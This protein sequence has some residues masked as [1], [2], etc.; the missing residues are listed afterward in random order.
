MVGVRQFN[1]EK[2]LD[3][4]MAVFWELGYEATSVDDLAKSTGLSRSSLYSAFG[5]KEE[6]FLKVIDRYLDGSRARFFDALEQDDLR[7]ALTD[8]LTILKDRLTDRKSKAGC[9]LVLAAENS[10]TKAPAI[11]RRVAEAFADEEKAFYDRFRRAQIDGQLAPDADARAF[12]RFFSA[13]GRAMG[14]NARVSSDHTAHD[15]IISLALSVVPPSPVHNK[16]AT[17]A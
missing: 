8:A 16:L 6:L 10:E 13:Q 17:S 9:L 7:A 15:D 2:A 11:R 14:I 4:A 3:A 12:A 1:T 5:N